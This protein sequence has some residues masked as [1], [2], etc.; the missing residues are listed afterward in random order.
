MKVCLRKRKVSCLIWGK[1]RIKIVMEKNYI[2]RLFNKFIFSLNLI[3]VLVLILSTFTLCFEP[4]RYRIFSFVGYLFP[5]M[6]IVNLFFLF[7][8]LIKRKLLFIISALAIVVTMGTSLSWFALNF[9]SHTIDKKDKQELSLLTYN[10]DAL[11]YNAKGN[12][13]EKYILSYNPDVICVQE[14]GWF[15]YKHRLNKGDSKLFSKYKYIRTDT[16][17]R[18]FSLVCLSKYPIIN[19]KRLPFESKSNN[20]YY[21]DIVVGKDTIRLINNHLESNKLTDKDKRDYKT[22]IENLESKGLTKVAYKVKSATSIRAREAIVVKDF[23]AKSPYRVI[24][25]GDFNDVPGSFVYR[26]VKGTLNDLWRKK[27]FG[28]GTS[29]SQKLFFFRIDYMFYS[30]TII[31]CKVLVGRKK[32]SDHYPLYGKF[33]L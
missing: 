3:V 5:I 11:T 12:N 16:K 27:G 9:N 25:C 33:Y 13:L 24:V 19:F 6:F 21:Y 10:I 32:Y 8:W 20:A 1:I 26:T 30:P 4:F 15:Y 22:S 17:N 7:Y 28:L 2:S 18:N 31:P 14:A 23:I 29:Y